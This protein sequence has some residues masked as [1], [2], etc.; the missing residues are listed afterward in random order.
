VEI[1]Y[2]VYFNFPAVESLIQED[3]IVES[4]EGEEKCLEKILEVINKVEKGDVI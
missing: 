3:I 1:L 2:V 4:I